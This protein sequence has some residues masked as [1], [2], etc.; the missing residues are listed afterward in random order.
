M[1]LQVQLSLQEFVKCW[2]Q[3]KMLSREPQSKSN[4]SKDE[5]WLVSETVPSAQSMFLVLQTVTA[6]GKDYPADL[7]H[8]EIHGTPL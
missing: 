2:D 8:P 5:H 7:P 3:L 6:V 1:L 4:N